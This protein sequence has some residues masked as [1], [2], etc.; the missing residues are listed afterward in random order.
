MYL[1]SYL[2]SLSLVHRSYGYIIASITC[3]YF[4]YTELDSIIDLSQQELTLS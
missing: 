3:L 2:D 1:H 4:L